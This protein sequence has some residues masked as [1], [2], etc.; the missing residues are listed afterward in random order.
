MVSISLG[1]ES[2]MSSCRNNSL[3]LKVLR[4]LR[5]PK[6][7]FITIYSIRGVRE[8]YDSDM[9]FGEEEGNHQFGSSFVFFLCG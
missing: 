6:T 2:E 7:F 9:E 3:S 4:K 8:N 1:S 5:P